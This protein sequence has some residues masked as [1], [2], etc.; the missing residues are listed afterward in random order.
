[1]EI[2]SLEE[3]STASFGLSATNG[4]QSRSEDEVVGPQPTSPPAERAPARR[5]CRIVATATTELAADEHEGSKEANDRRSVRFVPRP[6]VPTLSRAEILMRQ[7]EDVSVR[8]NP[9]ITSR[10]PQNQSLVCM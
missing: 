3:A 6:S 2:S 9:C 4:K 1:M 7:A 8:G 5:R 10:K